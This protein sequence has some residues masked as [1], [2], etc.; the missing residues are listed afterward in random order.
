M[1]TILKFNRIKFAKGSGINDGTYYITKAYDSQGIELYTEEQYNVIVNMLKNI[2]NTGDDRRG[3][4]LA[5]WI[6]SS[7]VI[8]EIKNGNLLL[9]HIFV[10]FIGD[11]GEYDL[12]VSDDCIKI[13]KLSEINDGSK[14][15]IGL[16]SQ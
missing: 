13:T 6:L 12:I 5:R 15:I 7:C 11:D 14:S 2:S 10:D 1:K 4:N 8:A 3:R 9:P 16:L